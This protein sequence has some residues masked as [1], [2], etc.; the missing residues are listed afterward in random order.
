[1]YIKVSQDLAFSNIK[2]FYI[3]EV[4]TPAPRET[5]NNLT[6]ILLSKTFHNSYGIMRPLQKG[7]LHIIAIMLKLLTSYV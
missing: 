2:R 6:T 5:E 7:A 4:L 1:M 3:K